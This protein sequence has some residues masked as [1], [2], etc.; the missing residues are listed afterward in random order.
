MMKI[1]G[2][3]TVG[4]SDGTPVDPQAQYFVLRLDT[5]P[6]ARVAARA[7]ASSIQSEDPLLSAEM[8][9]WIFSLAPR[10]ET[11]D[12]SRLLFQLGVMVFALREA[13]S[14]LSHYARLLNYHDVGHRPIYGSAEEWVSQIKQRLNVE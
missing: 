14:L 5:D 10:E 4:K 11:E 9:A 2:K 7:Y 6:H 12:T 13:I 3:Y 1:F 8:M